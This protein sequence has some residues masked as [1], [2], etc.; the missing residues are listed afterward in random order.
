MPDQS[1]DMPGSGQEDASVTLDL[2]IASVFILL[3]ASALG[4][5]PPVMMRLR[6]ETLKGTAFCAAKA[7]GGAV[8]LT[9]GTNLT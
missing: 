4:S 2:R 1:D 8:I 7:F 3:V 9:T 5:L 6:D